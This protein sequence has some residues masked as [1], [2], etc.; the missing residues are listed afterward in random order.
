[1]V[2]SQ[3]Y[4]YERNIAETLQRSFLPSILPSIDGY[5]D[6][7]FYRPAMAEARV[8]GDFYDLFI[9]A[10]GKANFVIGDVSG[11]G[12]KAA[13]PTAMG[14]YMIRAYAAEDVSPSNVLARFNRI[15]CEDA[16]EDMFM[17][18]FYGVLDPNNHTLTYANAGHNP[19]LFYSRSSGRI[20]QL[21]TAGTSL[22]IIADVSY[23]DS[24][25]R[26]QPGDVLLLYTDGATDVKGDSSRLELEGL[27][28][29]FLSNARA[30]AQQIANSISDG[31]WNYG[32]GKLPDD[33]ALLVLKR[34]EP[35]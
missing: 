1:V 22:G 19:P 28:Q 35:V 30:P 34:C 7:A 13:V 27:E 23:V 3:L 33:V 17:T 6:G 14:K 25:I 24:S 4:Q 8:G 2:N 11:K 29:L 26:F 21:I 10:D 16:P 5:E 15:F 32:H 9:T 31:I 18:A 20:E 12:L